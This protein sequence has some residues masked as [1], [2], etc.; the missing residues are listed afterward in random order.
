MIKAINKGYT[1]TVKS[2]ENDGDNSRTESKT[3]ATE[4]EAKVWWEMMQLC[5]SKNENRNVITLGN[6]YDGFNK[7]QKEVAIDFIKEHHE[8]L[9]PDDDIEANEENLADWFCSLAGE[10][11]GYSENYTC[12]VMESCVITFSLTDIFVTEIKYT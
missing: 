10:L 11:L 8:V 1:L 12:R 5:K 7:N 3:V 2:W 9:L 4:K 6:T